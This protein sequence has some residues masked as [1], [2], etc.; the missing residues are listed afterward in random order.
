MEKVSPEHG[1]FL[2]SVATAV[3]MGRMSGQLPFPG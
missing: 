2:S 3:E 1:M